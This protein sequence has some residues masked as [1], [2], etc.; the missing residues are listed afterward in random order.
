M[1]FTI[2]TATM[3]DLEAVAQVEA[4]CFPAAEA[5]TAEEFRQRLAVYPAHFWLLFQGERLI[6]FVDGFATD[7][8]DLTDRMFARAE[9]HQPEGAWQMIF[10]VNTLPEFRRQGLAGRLINR[11]IADARAQGR[12]GLVLTCK[13]Q[14]VHWYGGFGFVDEGITPHSTHGGVAWHQMRLTFQQVLV[15]HPASPEQRMQTLEALGDLAQVA[16]REPDWSQEVYHR[17]LEVAHIIL[18]EPKNE[19]LAYCR[20]LRWM[21]SSSS[22]ANYYVDGGVF[23][24]SAVLSCMTGLYGTIVSEH[25]LGMVLSLSRRLPEY[26]DQQRE[27][28]WRKLYYDKEL[29]GT[30]LLILGAGDIGTTLARWMRPMVGEIVG[31][32]RTKRKLAECYDRC[33]GMEELDEELEK[34][35]IVVGVLPHTPE[36]AGLLNEGRLRRMKDDAILVN[37]GRGSLI[38][39]DALNRLLD[40]GKFWGVGL[41]V[42][43]PEPLPPEHPLWRQ[44]RVLITPHTA[45]NTYAPH[46]PLDNA[47]WSTMLRRAKSVLQGNEPENVVD[48]GT[49][50]RKG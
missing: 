13:E 43:H 16:F 24:K 2:R 20:N 12:R 34:A 1:E 19:D 3:A 50:Y 32:C 45:G 44:K 8:E 37:G 7:E 36:T 17:H 22:G 11:A 46:S 35:D 21:Q 15:V 5:A 38:D 40:Q 47:I 41:E 23:P 10:G 48:F 28:G 39:S 33:I 26:R 6:S 29:F 31:L 9:L 25:L 30:S 49:G 18:G 4:A 27:G 14:L 42:T